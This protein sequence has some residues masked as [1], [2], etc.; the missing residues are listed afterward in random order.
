MPRNVTVKRSPIHGNGVFASK[1]LPA[2]TRVIQYKGKRR[3]HDEADELAQGDPDSGH[4]FLFTLNE[5]YIIDANKKGNAARWINHSCDPN[6]EAVI[7]ENENGKKKKDRIYIETIKP[8]SKGTELTYDYGITLEERHTK[9]LKD[10]WACKC[11]EPD[12]SGTM[13][14]SKDR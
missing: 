14:K 5:D 13:L 7:E 3:T 10:I 2:G 11:G 9:R 6:C 12:C 4:T 8:I 1:D